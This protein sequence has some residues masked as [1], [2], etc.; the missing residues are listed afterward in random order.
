MLTLPGAKVPGDHPEGK[1]VDCVFAPGS[2]SF[3]K[4]KDVKAGQKVKVR[5]KV[6]G[7]LPQGVRL[8]GCELLQVK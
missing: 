2:P 6:G 5:G 8:V 3:D 1:L 7:T 4:A